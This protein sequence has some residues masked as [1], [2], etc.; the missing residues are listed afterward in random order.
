MNTTKTIFH[1]YTDRED[2]VWAT[3]DYKES[4]KSF[5]NF[6]EGKSI[7]HI[8]INNISKSNVVKLDFIR[9]SSDY[10]KGLS[11]NGNIAIVENLIN[12]CSNLDILNLGSL[13]KE[14]FSID[15]L[16]NLRSI[17]MYFSLKIINSIKSKSLVK[18]AI[19]GIGEKDLIFLKNLTNIK[20]LT[21]VKGKL[22]ELNGIEYLNNIESLSLFYLNKLNTIEQLNEVKTSLKSLD[23]QNCKSI[24]DYSSLVNMSE[25]ERLL[26]ISSGNIVN[27]AFILGLTKLSHFSFVDTNIVDGDLS[28]CDGIKGFVGFNNKKH[29]NRKRQ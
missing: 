21:I 22:E 17:Y 16:V 15:K 3:F 5:L 28:Y 25:L 23:I 2:N 14:D 8:S 27:L 1:T 7:R 10:F 19:E 26:I 24:T 29:Y 9:E 20:D 6:I 18:L 12:E 11:I 13:I 4:I